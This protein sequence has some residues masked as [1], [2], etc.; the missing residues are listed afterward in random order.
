[1]VCRVYRGLGCKDLKRSYL[2]RLH[3]T[4]HR[5][6]SGAVNFLTH[7]QVGS[8]RRSVDLGFRV[9]PKPSS[10]GLEFLSIELEDA[11]LLLDPTYFSNGSAMLSRGR[12]SSL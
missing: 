8:K 5:E 11:G 1:M 10:H 12:T 6:T 7:P 2:S 4:R 9:Y 3:N